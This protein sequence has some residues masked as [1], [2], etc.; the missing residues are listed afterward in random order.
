MAYTKNTNFKHNKILIDK[1]SDAESL[2]I[3]LRRKFKSIAIKKMRRFK[4]TKIKKPCFRG[5]LGFY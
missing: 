1:D 4:I 2:T 3:I 5:P